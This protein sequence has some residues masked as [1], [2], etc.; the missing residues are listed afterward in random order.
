MGSDVNWKKSED[1]NTIICDFFIKCYASNSDN[2][3]QIFELML[4]NGAD[5]NILNTQKKTLLEVIDEFSNNQ[6][7][8]PYHGKIN[9]MK[10]IIMKKLGK[11]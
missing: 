3:L 11:W 7:V 8:K 10:R 2:C 9:E 1:E 4:D 6:A 5:I